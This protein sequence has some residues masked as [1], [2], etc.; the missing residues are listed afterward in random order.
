M[1]IRKFE[2]IREFAR[3]KKINRLIYTT[4]TYEQK[5]ELKRYIYNLKERT[6][7]K[8][9]MWEYLNEPLDDEYFVT[10]SIILRGYEREKDDKD[11]N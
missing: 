7:R 11:N 5:K 3:E 9:L 6:C 2:N 8:D 10:I 4:M 1:E